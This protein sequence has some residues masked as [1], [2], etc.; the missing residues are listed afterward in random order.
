ML[1][2]T[3]TSSPPIHLLSKHLIKRPLLRP[4]IPTPFV[5]SIPTSTP[6]PARASPPLETQT[7][8]RHLYGRFLGRV[9]F[10][11]RPRYCRRVG[12]GWGMPC[13]EEGDGVLEYGEREDV[14]D[15]LLQS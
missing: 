14:Q 11:H 10:L 4:L 15:V 6:F 8:V 1:V 5:G 12:C 7:L 3:S 9:V 2:P 13:W